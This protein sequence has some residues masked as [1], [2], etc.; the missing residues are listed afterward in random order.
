MHLKVVT[1]LTVNIKYIKWLIEA[2]TSF[3]GAVGSGN[4]DVLF[5]VVTMQEQLWL[6]EFSLTDHNI[7]L[8]TLMG[9]LEFLT[10]A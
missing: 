2:I 9:N 5:A 3:C 6:A 7:P 8:G 10:L 1:S 4:K